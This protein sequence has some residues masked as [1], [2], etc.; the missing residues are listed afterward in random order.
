MLEQTLV[1]KSQN[2]NLNIFSCDSSSIGCNASLSIGQ[3]LAEGPAFSRPQGPDMLVLHN[4]Q[5]KTKLIKFEAKLIWK[6]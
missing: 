4:L 2:G 1:K 6:V 5:T 3:M